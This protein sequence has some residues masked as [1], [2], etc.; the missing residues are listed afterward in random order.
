MKNSTSAPQSNDFLLQYYSLRNISCPEDSNSKRKVLT[1]HAPITSILGLP[2]NENVRDYLL[3]AEGKKRKRPTAVHRAIRD[4]LNNYPDKFSIL[5]GGIVIVARDYSVDE[6]S[7][8]V[9]L[10]KPSIINGSQT[11]GTI[12][13]FVDGRKDDDLKDIHV[14]FELIITSD[15]SLIA[16]ISIARNFQND[17][18]LLSI[19]GRLGELDDLNQAVCSGLP[20][21]KLRRSETELSD[22][23]IDTESL[24]QIITVLIPPEL[25]IKDKDG[26]FPNKT[27]A[28]TQ[29]ARC[30]K[31]FRDIH[32]AVKDNDSNLSAKDRERYE[33]LYQFYLDI[34]PQA[35]KLH[36][37]WRTHQGFQGTGL[38]AIQRNGRE[39]VD[40]PD[41]IVFPILASL[42]LFAKQ[43]EG[44]WVIDPPE[45]FD[46]SEVIN[47]AKTAYQQIANSKPHLMGR[48]KAC[49]SQITQVTSIY[50]RLSAVR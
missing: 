44:K 3:E 32:K 50:K 19:A 20:G 18:K 36:H 17:V 22:K 28:Y 41:G 14:T 11:Q 6:K 30:L 27:F 9:K 24:L 26:D 4:T 15:E 42:S 29:R 8:V 13:E 31:D 35:Y 10:D 45:L 33:S 34:E 38:R 48:N 46:D 37:E 47:A 12:K 5:N 16:E 7:K 49:Y 21:K 40:V 25:W 2:T 23:Y 39:I 43:L 1:G